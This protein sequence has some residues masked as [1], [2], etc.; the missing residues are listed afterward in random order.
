[1]IPALTRL[2]LVAVVIFSPLAAQSAIVTIAS[3]LDPLNEVPPVT[4]APGAMGT[5]AALLDTDTGQFGWV[6][7]FEGLTG[8]AV[9]AH[10]HEAPAG[11]NGPIVI[12]LAPGPGVVFSDLGK[13]TGTFVGGSTL[14][15]MD[16]NNLLAGMWYINIHTEINPGGEVRGQVLPGSFQPIPLP[17]SAVLLGT[18]LIGLAAFRKKLKLRY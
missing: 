1:M 5:A 16:M 7:G 4:N 18:A 15:A 3:L 2:F 6:I 9:A 17:A 13:D 10:F 11:S 12:S 14:S 8:P